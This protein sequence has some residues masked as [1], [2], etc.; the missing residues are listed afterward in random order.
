[1]NAFETDFKRACCS[2]RFLVSLAA[3]LLI[4]FTS[5]MDSELFRMSVPV[6]CTLPYACGFSDE[7]KNGFVKFSL[8]RSSFS[9]YIFGKFLA[10][11]I[12]G[13]LSETVPAFVYQTIKGEEVGEVKYL[14]LFLSAFLWASLASLLAAL[15]NSKYAAYGGAF[16][17]YHFMIILYDRYWEDLYCLYPYEWLQPTHTWIFDETGVAVLLVMLIVLLALCYDLVLRRRLARV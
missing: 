15:S 7:Y 5:G 1:M 13:G 17:L 12:A 10:C 3:E 6:V 2:V 4:L 9:G 16:V 14:L 8:A 11:G